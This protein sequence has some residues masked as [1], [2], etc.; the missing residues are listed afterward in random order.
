MAKRTDGRRISFQRRELL[1]GALH[2]QQIDGRS[3]DNVIASS[4]AS[5]HDRCSNLDHRV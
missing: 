2:T 1:A 4:R 5:V 3:I